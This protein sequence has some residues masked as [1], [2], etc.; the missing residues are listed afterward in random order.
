[1][2]YSLFS[3][4]FRCLSLL[5]LGSLVGSLSFAQTSGNWPNKPVTLVVT[6]PPGGGAAWHSGRC[7]RRTQPPGYSHQ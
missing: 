1:M 2:R 5:I 4:K 7:G 3:K 6:Y